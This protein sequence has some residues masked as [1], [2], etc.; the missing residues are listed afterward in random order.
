MMDE[1][2]QRFRLGLPHRAALRKRYPRYVGKIDARFCSIEDIPSLVLL[3]DSPE[4]R[5]RMLKRDTDIDVCRVSWAS[6]DVVVKCYKHVGLVHSLRHTLKRSRAARCWSNA[7]LLLRQGV[8]TPKPLAFI[9]EYRGALLRRSFLATEFTPGRR[10]DEVLRDDSLSQASRRRTVSCVLR[11]IDR[12]ARHGISHGD[13]KHT[14]ILYDGA[15]LILTDL[16]G[17]CV[18]H[19]Q[20]LRRRRRARDISRFLRDLSQ[21]APSHT[22]STDDTD[23]FVKVS[24]HKGRLLVNNCLR[25]AHFE[26]AMLN[27]PIS[28]CESHR[29]DRVVSS[30]GSRVWR[31]DASI[32]GTTRHIY[33]KEYVQRSRLDRVKHLVRTNRAQRAMKGSLLLGRAGLKTPPIAAI[34]MVKTDVLKE[35]YFMATIEVPDARPAHEYFREGCEPYARFT[36]RDR[37][38]ILRQ[39]GYE[40]GRM[41]RAGIVHGDLRPGNILVRR[42]EQ[43]WEFFFI[44]NERTRQWPCIPRKLRLKNLVQLNMLPHEISNTDRLRFFHA[45]M[46]SNPSV[47]LDYRAWAAN[48]MIV[49]HK[50]F[51]KKGWI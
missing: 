27:D 6:R 50:R 5:E 36:L 8:T 38:Q 45:Y 46:L 32:G 19:L 21:N 1:N 39:L 2:I 33:L 40:I 37:R 25:D 42:G 10:L 31:F 23:S 24:S 48:V 30:D 34:S 18:H 43:N 13:M 47:R 22:A 4:A 49:T 12:L 41:H 7:Y 44:D 28:L 15:K 35:R 9:D 26:Q 17:M 3:V 14:N 16:D 29:S 11:W 20:W 51:H